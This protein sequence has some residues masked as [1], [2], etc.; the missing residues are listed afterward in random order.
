M[1]PHSYTKPV[2]TTPP[3]VAIVV[4]HSRPF[5][6]PY[7]QQL[8]DSIHAQSYPNIELWAMD[9]TGHGRTEGELRN[10]AVRESKADLVLFM[11]EEDALI[12][13]YVASMVALYQHAKASQLDQLV[14]ISSG[15]T[16]LMPDGRT[17]QVT[18]I[19]APGMYERAFLESCPFD[20]ELNS[21]VDHMQQVKLAQRAQ[22]L[23]KPVTFATT[24]HYGYLLRA[25][26]FR[27]DGITIR[28]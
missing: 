13:D 25:I 26:T 21:R 6:G 22:M 4:V 16:A 9:N 24:H 15:V 14:Y 12:V 8:L 27:R 20:V 23:G 11:A 10:Q 1:N 28:T 18:N 5:D 19:T 17:L 7:M 3:L 2:D